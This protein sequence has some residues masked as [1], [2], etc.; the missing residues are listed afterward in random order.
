MTEQK[1]EKSTYDK[2][3]ARQYYV[4]NRE[5]ILERQRQYNL[6]NHDKIKR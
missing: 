2:E 6:E 3:K 1:K 5:H 4:N